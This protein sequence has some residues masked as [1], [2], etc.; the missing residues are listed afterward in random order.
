[1]EASLINADGIA[2]PTKIPR[3]IFR[4]LVPAK[5][6]TS[7]PMRLSSPYLTIVAPIARD[8][9]MNQTASW[10]YVATTFLGSVIPKNN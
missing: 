8:P 7:I 2:V 1:M 3:T 4:T 6:I 9:A 10:A 5:F